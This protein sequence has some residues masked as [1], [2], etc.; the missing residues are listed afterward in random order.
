M[1]PRSKGPVILSI[2]I[3]STFI[4]SA[5]KTETIVE[6]VEVPVEVEVDKP[7]EVEV[8]ITPTP[9]PIPSGG[10]IVESSIADAQILNPIL[11]SDS[12]SSDV[13]TKLF[14]GLLTLDEFTGEIIGEIA[15]SWTTS[16]DGLTYTFKLRGDIFWTDGTPVTAKD[17][18]FTY[19]AIASELVDTPRKSNIELVEEFRVVD[20]YTLEIEF[21]TLDCT[22]LQN[23]TLGILPSHMYAEDFSDI[24]ESPLNQEP[25]VT[26]GPFKFQE[27]IKDDHVTLVQNDDFYLGASNLDGWIMRIVA[28]SSAGLA[29]FLA[30]EVDITGVSPQFVS[31]IEGEIAKGSPFVMKKFFNDGYQYVGFNMANPENPEMGWVDADESGEFEEGEAPNLEQEPHPI[32]GDVRVRQAISYSLDYTNMI[33][34]VAFGQGAPIVAN[35]LPA[36]EWAYNDDLEPYVLDTEMAEVLLDE[37]GWAR[38]GEG[39]VR[40]KDGQPLALSILTNAGAETRENIAAIMKDNLDALGFDITLD[41]LEWGTVVGKLLGQQYDMVIIGWIGMGSDPEDSVFWAYRYDDP[42]GGFNFV[43]YY[44]EEVEELLFE[45]KSLPGCSTEAR[46]EKYRRIQELI[47]EDAPYAFLINSLGNVIWNTRL[48][49]VEPGPWSTYYNVHT[50]Y[51]KP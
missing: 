5:Y 2:F 40:M 43:S 31:V 44:N 7:V 29:A 14:L 3:I 49:G 36:I 11:S 38:E 45:A 1:F 22:A 9:E 35:V 50:W 27:W 10:F 33:N 16:E 51:L 39:G 13:H 42:G 26:N 24:M 41:I 47:H 46:S 28:D 32:L 6:T 12:P 34:K 17:I 18:K 20:D 30:G 19:D 15:E 37:A 48:R 25:T 8:L 23:L 21:H 4:L